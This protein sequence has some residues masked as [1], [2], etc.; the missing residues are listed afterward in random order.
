M[1]GG[2]TLG[3]RSARCRLNVTTFVVATALV[4]YWISL[5]YG[6][7]MPLPPG[8]LPGHSDKVIHFTSYAGLAALLMSL[9]ATRGIY[10]WS[11][12]L[13]RGFILAVYGVFDE[14]TQLFVNR[15]ADF[16]DWC[17]DLVGS[18]AGLASVTFVLWCLRRSDRSAEFHATISD[19]AS[20]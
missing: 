13:A 18:T 16:Y 8:L 9:R 17:A 4:V 1:T 3:S 7:H 6:T 10:P 19:G 15:S 2:S 5:F 14:L 11:S 12:V 20:S